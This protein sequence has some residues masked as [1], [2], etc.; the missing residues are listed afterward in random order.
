MKTVAARLRVLSVVSI[1]ALMLLAVVAFIT[2]AG[3]RRS[4]DRLIQERFQAYVGL[5]DLEISVYSA[6][7]QTLRLVN[8]ANAGYETAKLEGLAQEIL[9]RLDTAEG[10][11]KKLSASGRNTTE[12]AAIRT[13]FDIYVKQLRDVVDIAP[14]GASMAT[15][16]LGSAED[17]FQGFRT[18]LTAL[19]AS[20]RA[21]MQQEANQVRTA[22]LR[23]ILF[24]VVVA[25]GMGLVGWTLTVRI[26]HGIQAPLSLLS[27][28]IEQSVLGRDLTLRMPE[29]REDEIGRLS[30]AFNALSGSLQDFFLGNGDRSASLASGAEELSSS[31]EEMARTSS[32]M[33][34]GAGV[35]RQGT[36][37]MESAVRLIMDAV[38]DTNRVASN[39]GSQSEQAL[40]AAEEGARF[41]NETLKAMEA[42]LRANQPMARAAVMI[43]EIANQTNLLSLNA[44]IEAAKAGSSG[45]GFAVVAEEIRK[46]AERSSQATDQI[47]A[48]L[49]ESGQAITRGTTTVGTTVK[50]LLE[51]EDRMRQIAQ[52]IQTFT[53]TVRTQSRA[54]EDAASQVKV[55]GLEVDQNLRAVSELAAAI[56]EVARTASDLASISDEMRESVVGYKVK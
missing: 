23:G 44:A 19:S 25:L 18:S 45:K 21:K 4:V 13:S 54:S 46:L 48:L 30:R 11:L 8:W 39:L 56:Q 33:A 24:F 42:I 20:E 22:A 53:H 16:L 17:A 15:M 36:D 10:A 55:V 31:S 29:D 1:G 43:Q 41:G 34:E 27:E 50:A 51:I 28:R 9:A 35:L 47:Q 7:G 14:T 49:G 32:L 6:Q 2:L 52:M 26:S 12:L 37:A 3:Q 40:A 38:G 5:T